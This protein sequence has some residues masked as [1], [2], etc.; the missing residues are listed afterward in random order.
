MLSYIDHSNYQSK[1]KR[2]WWDLLVSDHYY[3][4]LSL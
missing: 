2:H 3:L 4:V 1:D